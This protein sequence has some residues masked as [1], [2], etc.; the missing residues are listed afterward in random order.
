[1][2][3]SD[4]T[5]SLVRAFGGPDGIAQEVHST[6]DD[7]DTPA[8]VKARLLTGLLDLVVQNTKVGGEKGV[9]SLSDEELLEELS[10]IN[11]NANPPA[12]AV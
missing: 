6:Y 12:P 5:A 1:M 11:L 7:P 8:S 9:G 2:N 3:T 4:I 10:A